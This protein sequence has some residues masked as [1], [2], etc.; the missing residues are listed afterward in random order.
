MFAAWLACAPRPGEL[1]PVTVSPIPLTEGIRGRLAWR[2][3]F[4]LDA[5]DGAWGGW[6]G[7]SLDGDVLWAVSD[8]GGFLSLKL[9]RDAEGR[10]VDVVPEQRGAL[11]DPGGRPLRGKFDADAEGLARTATAFFVSFEHDHRL[12]SYPTLDSRSPT[13]V[14]IP[15][16]FDPPRNG[17]LE[18]VA[19]ADERLWIAAEGDEGDAGP[20]RAWA[21][22]PGAWRPFTIRR[23]P[24]FRVVDWT[25]K[26][27]GDLIMIERSYDERTGVRILVSEISTRGA[28]PESGEVSPR[29]LG[30]LAPPDPPMDNYEAAAT[31]GRYLY[32]LAD[33]NQSSDQRTLLLQ[34]EV[35]P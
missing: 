19:W 14:A 23:E 28:P 22:G 30:R 24:G 13:L 25:P 17:G 26:P 9:V 15:P 32:L 20:T 3:A 34:L 2:A 31:D 21:G 29:P 5:D 10:L 4:A 11:S 12:M 18:A 7:A 8:V 35:L 16:T 1:R 6:S 33:D 27:D